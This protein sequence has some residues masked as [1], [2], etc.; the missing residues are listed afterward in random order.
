MQACQRY[1]CRRKA[2]GNCGYPFGSLICIAC[3][4]EEFGSP[5]KRR[6]AITDA[7]F[8]AWEAWLVAACTSNMG[9][10]QHTAEADP[11]IWHV[12]GTR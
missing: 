6:K 9:I 11:V 5:S 3:M 4:N 1:W 8:R 12:Y 7:V 2:E 10:R